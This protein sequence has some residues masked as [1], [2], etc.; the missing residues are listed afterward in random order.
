MEL[1]QENIKTPAEPDKLSR[2]TAGI[3]WCFLGF[4]GYLLSITS[5]ISQKKDKGNKKAPEWLNR[6]KQILS[7]DVK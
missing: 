5:I 6:S 2:L 4:V 3:S 1:F 7:K